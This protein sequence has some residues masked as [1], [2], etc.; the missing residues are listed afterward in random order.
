MNRL[1]FPL[2][3]VAAATAALKSNP[4]IAEI[5]LMTHFANADVADGLSAPM[6][7]IAPLHK[8]YNRVSLANSAA[9]LLHGDINDDWGRIGIALYG[10][11]P[12]PA[13]QNNKALGCAP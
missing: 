1:G 6:A 3:E 5:V 12:A 9:A 7:K 11:S 8:L 13:W 10:S 4:A 2:A